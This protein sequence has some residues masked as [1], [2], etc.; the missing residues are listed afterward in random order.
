MATESKIVFNFEEM[1]NIYIQMKSMKTE[2]E[3]SYERIKKSCE[4]AEDHMKG[5]YKK[6]FKEE[7]E[8]VLKSFKDNI[9]DLTNLAGIIEGASQDAVGLDNSIAKTINK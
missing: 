1:K 6:A 8:K 3:E 4:N 5:Q 9:K 2:A 7:T